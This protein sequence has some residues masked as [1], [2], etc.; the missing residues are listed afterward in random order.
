[1]SIERIDVGK[2]RAHNG[3]Y[4]GTHVLGRQAREMS[5]KH[6]VHTD[7]EQSQNKQKT[8]TAS[9]TMKV[10]Q[11]LIGNQPSKQGLTL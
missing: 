11:W 9:N 3:R 7:V 1:M 2:Q 4:T 5:T 10:F 6:S 8:P